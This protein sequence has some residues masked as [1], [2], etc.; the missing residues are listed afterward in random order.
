MQIYDYT[1]DQFIV[2]GIILILA[3]WDWNECMKLG[4]DVEI[5]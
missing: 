1:L 4:Y 3:I 5:D 2:S